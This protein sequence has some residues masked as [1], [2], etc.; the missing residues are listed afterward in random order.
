MSRMSSLGLLWVRW[1]FG[2]LLLLNT[3][4]PARADLHFS[5]SRVQRGTVRSGV[6]LAQRFDFVNRGPGAVT[7][8]DLRASCGCLAPRLEKRAYRPGESGAILLEVHTLSQPAGSNVWRVDVRYQATDQEYVASL[9]LLAE[10]ITEVKVE[11]AKLMFSTAGTLRH[12]VVVTDQRPRPLH[13]TQA[14][15]S[16]P[17]ILAQV[18][19]A[20]GA[21]A[22]VYRVALEVTDQLPEGKHEEVLSIFTDDPIYREL[23]VPVT[24]IKRSRQSVSAAP[25]TVDLIIPRGQPAPSRIVLLRAEGDEEVEVEQVEVD[26]PALRCRWTKGPGKMATLKISVDHTRVAETLKGTVRVHVRR[27]APACLEIPVFYTTR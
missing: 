1:G 18:K 16:S 25:A 6:P 8:T 23:R 24:V 22:A 15:C 4:A 26:A 7:I 27:P 12:E 5:Q 3:R 13:V 21:P 11:P 2:L 20:E 10:L 19:A 14:R 9:E 17:F